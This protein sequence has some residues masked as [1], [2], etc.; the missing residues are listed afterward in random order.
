MEKE[1]RGLKGRGHFPIPTIT[2]HSTRVETLHHINKFL[3]AVD[4]EMVH[5]ITAVRE[6]E[7]NYE[8][9]K[10]EARIRDQQ[11]KASRSTHRPEY[12]FFTLNSS[13]PIKNTGTTENQNRHTERSIHFNPNPIHHLY[14]TTGTTSHNGWYEPPANDLIIQ[15]AGTATGGQFTTN[16]ASATGHN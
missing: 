8:K 16:V 1:L 4:E 6:S 5:I 7:R 9:E 11:T 15:G 10:E 13:T 3:E 12:N 2:P 14:S